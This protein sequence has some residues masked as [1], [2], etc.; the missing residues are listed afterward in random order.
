M[1]APSPVSGADLMSMS[2]SM[3][4]IVLDMSIKQ[5]LRRWEWR[6]VRAQPCAAVISEHRYVSTL[7]SPA[8]PRP[9]ASE[10]IPESLCVERREAVGWVALPSPPCLRV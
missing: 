8:P 7:P 4:L 9:L 10:D 1:T 5:M 2:M 3:S 6:Q